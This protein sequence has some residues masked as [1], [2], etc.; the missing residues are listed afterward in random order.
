MVQLR[1]VCGLPPQIQTQATEWLAQTV[2]GLRFFVFDF[3]VHGSRVGAV[4]LGQLET[5][6][7][8]QVLDD[9][10]VLV[11]QRDVP[12]AH[13][14]SVQVV[15]IGAGVEESGERGEA[16]ASRCCQQRR[17][18]I[19]LAGH[20]DIGAARDEQ[21]YNVRTPLQCCLVQRR[22]PL[23]SCS[24]DVSA[25]VDEQT[26]HRHV[27]RLC[28]YVQPCR[29]RPLLGSIHTRTRTDELRCDGHVSPLRCHVQRCAS[30][31]ERQ[32]HVS[33]DGEEGACVGEA[34]LSRSTHQWRVPL[35]VARVH[36]AGR[37]DDF[38]LHEELKKLL[39]PK[40]QW[41]WLLCCCCSLLAASLL[42]LLL[43]PRARLFS[44]CCL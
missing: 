37:V 2:L 18:P 17:P 25:A 36:L 3:G 1:G 23:L 35:I 4:T 14:R 28:R 43:L 21:A 24:V 9:V 10:R 16:P 5:L 8:P 31:R 41:R 44:C 42:F 20:V 32:M 30:V 38:Q 15:D 40:R 13:L 34:A 11:Q 29:S 22:I 19:I 12:D 39:L 26:H 6:F 27:P 7:V 33:A